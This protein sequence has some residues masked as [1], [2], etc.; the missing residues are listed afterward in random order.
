MDLQKVMRS[1]LIFLIMT[2][3]VYAVDSTRVV[4]DLRARVLVFKN[5]VATGSRSLTTTIVEGFV[6][7]AVM[8]VYKSVGVAKSKVIP[9]TRASQAYLVDEGLLSITSAVLDTSGAGGRSIRGLKPLHQSQLTEIS[10]TELQDK[11]VGRPRYYTRHGDSIKLWNPIHK[12]NTATDSLKIEYRAR[13]DYP[14]ATSDAPG[15][16][17]E[18]QLAI[19]FKAAEFCSMRQRQWDDAAQWGRYFDKQVAIILG[20]ETNEEQQATSQIP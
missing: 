7:D 11:V 19:I 6:Q 9:V 3:S 18:H 10:Y 13:G 1:L 2:S 17:W 14:E 12:Y 16:V 8:E 4:T 5:T 15:T 20:R